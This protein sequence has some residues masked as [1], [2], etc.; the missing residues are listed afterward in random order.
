MFVTIITDCS[1]ANASARQVTRYESYLGV[2]AFL[3]G[4]SMPTTNLDVLPG[5]GELET[6]TNLID[7]LDG[8][9]GGRGI[10]IANVA[11]RQGQGKH[12]PNGTPFGYFLYKQTLVIATIDGYVLSLV[13]KLG[14]TDHIKV[15]DIPTVVDAMIKLGYLEE[16]KRDLIVKSQFRSFEFVPRVAKWLTEGIDVPHEIYD[17]SKV[18]DA[19][20]CISYVDNFGNTVTTMLPEDIG[21][22]AGKEITTKFGTFK[23]Y[24][25]MKDVPNGE[26][27]FIIGSWGIEDKRWVAFIIQG[28]SAAKKYNL[29]PGTE[30]F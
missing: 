27:A 20:K 9:E 6:A 16:K 24:D 18:A 29:S 2:P 15:F 25:R 13:K 1:D 28:Q 19:P 26:T 21:F 14:L 30:L 11:P 17:I 23:C 5:F 3:V 4:V 12:W 10:A 8:A 7:I 22:V